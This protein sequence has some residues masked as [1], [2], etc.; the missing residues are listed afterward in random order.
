[1][2]K[3]FVQTLDVHDVLIIGHFYKIIFE[4]VPN[5]NSKT[6]YVDNYIF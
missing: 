4:R 2:F 5:T 6:T 3:K 1:M